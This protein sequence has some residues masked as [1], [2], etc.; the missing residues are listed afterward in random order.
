MDL[1][2]TLD[3]LNEMVASESLKTSTYNNLLKML[4]S[5]LYFINFFIFLFRLG[6]WKH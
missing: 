3:L 1:E 5:K 2:K 4:Q 6:S